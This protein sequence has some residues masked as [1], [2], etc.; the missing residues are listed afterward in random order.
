MVSLHNVLHQIVECS[1]Q[2]NRQFPK[3]AFKTCL[4][5]WHKRSFPGLGKEM[6]HL[7][8]YRMMLSLNA[9]RILF[10]SV[11]LMGPNHKCKECDGVMPIGK[12]RI[13]NRQLYPAL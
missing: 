13:T 5:C 1:K 2:A 11:D 12:S 7:S 4:S 9:E 3:T 10:K 6:C 8:H